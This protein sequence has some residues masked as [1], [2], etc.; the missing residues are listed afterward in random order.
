MV[1]Q[2]LAGPQ[3]WPA[4]DWARELRGTRQVGA[5]LGATSQEV[6][7]DEDIAEAFARFCED[8]CSVGGSCD[9]A[10]PEEQHT[11]HLLSSIVLHMRMQ[12][13]IEA[14]FT[15]EQYGFR[16]GRGC[17]NALHVLRLVAE[18]S[19]EWGEEL[20]VATL[21]VEK[22]F[23]RVSRDQLIEA[24]TSTGAD[25]CMVSV[26]R[27]LHRRMTAYAKLASRDRARLF[28]G[29]QT[30]KKSD[31]ETQEMLKENRGLREANS[32]LDE[33]LE[34]GKGI[35]DNLIGQNTV[36]KGA[37]KKLLDAANVMGVSN[38]L[39]KVIDRRQ[40]GDKYI[41]YGGMAFV[42]FL[43]LSLWYLLRM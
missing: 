30:D 36:L 21:D 32:A 20:W 24:L 35:L 7:R 22:A 16:K 39:V 25:I 37:R 26:L 33:V 12:E 10:R 27:K 3:A 34:S 2:S 4:A 6:T 9:K 42:L 28:S 43:L 31:D 18:K 8:L 23:D 13:S 17:D 19:A 11:P 29:R 5:V 14:Y 40:T 41:V 38:S 15:E 1:P